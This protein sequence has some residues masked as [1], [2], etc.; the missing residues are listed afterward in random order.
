MTHRVAMLVYDD[1]Q[2]LDIAGPLEVFARASRWLH[3]HRGAAG[4]YSV[5]LVARS[6]RPI[7]ASNG[8]S[9]GPCRAVGEAGAPD[10]LLVTGG[11]GWEAA[12]ADRVLIDWLRK[13]SAG[14]GRTGAIC[15]GSLILAAAGLVRGRQVTTHWAY[16]DRFAEIEP[17]CVVD[18]TSIYVKSGPIVTSAGVTAGMDMALS[19]VEA[20]HGKPV[21]LHVAQELVMFLRRPGHQAQFSRHV[22]AELRDSPFAALER[23]VLDSLDADLGVAALAGRTGLSE[24]HFVRRFTAEIGVPPATWV[25][26][27]RVA[28]ARRQIEQGAPSLKDV[29]RRCGFGDEQRL[30]RAFVATLGVTPSDYAARFA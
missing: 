11:I 9:V 4:S 8:L 21:A 1:A 25:R 16:L 28:A 22:A 29:A 14:A 7:R 24:R 27:L 30:R 18:R 10:T 26:G 13:A 3:E 17:D 20:D 23:W 15:T 2:M 5:E 12:A 19:L 6:A